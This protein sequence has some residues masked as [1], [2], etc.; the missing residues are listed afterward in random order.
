MTP[1]AAPVIR[2]DALHVPTVV[3]IAVEDSG[4]ITVVLIRVIVRVSPAAPLVMLLVASPAQQVVPAVV[5]AADPS[6]MTLSAALLPTVLLATQ[7]SVS[8]ASLTL[9]AV[10]VPST[11]MPMAFAVT[12]A[13]PLAMQS[14]ASLA[15]RRTIAAPLLGDT[16]QAPVVV[17]VLPAV[18]LAMIWAASHAPIALLTVVLRIESLIMRA[19]VSAT[20]RVAKLVIS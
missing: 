20:S 15:A 8:L 12:K 5:L 19:I 11:K 14:D 6:M 13:A 16:T 18:V 2:S 7:P 1:V 10:Q 3:Q 17:L 9:S 4:S